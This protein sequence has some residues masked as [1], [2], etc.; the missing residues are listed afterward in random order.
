MDSAASHIPLPSVGWS[1]LAASQGEMARPDAAPLTSAPSTGKEEAAALRARL[2]S[3]I[4]DSE[5]SRKASSA[6]AFNAR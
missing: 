1:H 6:E 5:R 3:M 2:L 4:A